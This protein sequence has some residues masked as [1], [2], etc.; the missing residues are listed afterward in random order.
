MRK[1]INSYSWIH[2]LNKAS[3][4]AHLLSEA[5]KF[6]NN[7]VLN[8][9]TNPFGKAKKITGPRADVLGHEFRQPAQEPMDTGEMQGVDPSV[10]SRLISQELAK[11]GK[12]SAHSISL[13]PEGADVKAFV[14][15]TRQKTQE[16][17]NKLK[18]LKPVDVDGDMD[19]DAED[20]KLDVADGVGDGQSMTRLPSFPW[21]HTESQPEMRMHAPQ[22]N[23]SGMTP[24]E[25]TRKANEQL[26]AD[27]VID[28]LYSKMDAD[29]E[30]K[31]MI[32]TAPAGKMYSIQD[33]QHIARILGGQ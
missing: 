30:M 6:A 9:E 16:R 28:D 31:R 22:Q 13:D 27:A 11:Y 10:Y 12:P 2:E 4:E 5:K 23:F 14:D 18:N 1:K 26:K 29:A 7:K 21:A 25:I 17:I 24:N 33:L 20:V 32:K 3:M 15:I 19:A 8:E